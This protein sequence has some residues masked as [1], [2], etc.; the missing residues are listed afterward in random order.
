MRYL[1]PLAIENIIEWNKNTDYCASASQK[2]L[3]Y[4][5]QILSFYLVYNE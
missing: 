3:D 2:I 4:D 1:S 5:E